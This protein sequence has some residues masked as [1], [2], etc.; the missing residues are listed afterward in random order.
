MKFATNPDD[1]VRIAYELVGEGPPL[2]LFHGSL[3]S[4]ALWGA[5]GYVDALRAEYRLILVDARG[6]GHS[7]KPTTMDSYAMER[8]VGDVIAVLDDSDLPQTAYLGYSMGGRVGFGLAIRAPERVRALVVGGASHRP[9]HEALDRLIYPGFVDTIEMEGIEPFL[10]Q[11]S[12]AVRTR[13]KPGCPSGLPRQRPS[14]SRSV[15]PT[16]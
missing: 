11:W 15:P 7:D 2:L 10:E 4:G 14:R 9:Q 6:H 13:G 3:T 1:G 16:D 5:L 12:A 8:L